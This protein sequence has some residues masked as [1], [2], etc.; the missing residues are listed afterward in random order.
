M[1]MKIL[2]NIKS[3]VFL[4]GLLCAVLIW[5][6]GPIID[7]YIFGNR[8][9]LNIGLS[10][11]AS[12]DIYEHILFSVIILLLSLVVSV[13]I[14]VAKERQKVF[15]T[16]FDNSPNSLLLVSDVGIITLVNDTACTMFGFSRE[17]LEGMQ[18]EDLIPFR[19]RGRH[20]G[21]RENYFKNITTRAMG[22]GRELYGLRSDGTEF[23]VEIGLTGVEFERGA[24]NG[25]MKL[26]LGTITDI[27]ARKRA[28]EKLNYFATH[29][30]L[31]GLVNRHEFERRVNE[32]LTDI[33]MNR[34]EHALCYIDLDQFRVI[35][36]TCGHHAGDEMLQ[37][38][39]MVLRNIVRDRDT[40]ARL[41]G[42]EFAVLMQHCS[43]DNAVRVAENLLKSINDFQYNYENKMFR[44]GASIGLVAITEELANFR[45]LM[46]QAD[47]ACFTAKEAGRNRVHV[48]KAYEEHAS[49]QHGDMKWVAVLHQA[50][51]EDRLRLYAQAIVPLDGSDDTHYELL[52]RMLDDD[53]GVIPPGQFLPAAERYNI[54]SKIDRW[55]IATAFEKVIAVETGSDSIKLSINLSAQSLNEPGFLEYVI[56][57]I[58]STGINANNICFEITETAAIANLQPARIFMT[59]LK[60]IGC[61]FALDDFGTGHS[62]FG[63]LKKL[64]VDYLKIDGV[65][66]KEIVNDRIDLAMVKSIN[67]IGHTMGMKT[68]AEFVENNEIKELLQKIGVNYAQGYGIGKPVPLEEK[69]E[70][71][72]LEDVTI[73]REAASA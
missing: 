73:M 69:L 70:A 35:N 4:V 62:S 36:D 47:L 59:T 20:A 46:K 17:K 9:D 42:D 32:M 14:D 6:A 55:V 31:T 25:G 72:E 2:K 22:A 23:P 64:P 65:F 43:V 61:K 56:E 28:E 33:D 50:L 13:L 19:Y 51:A 49:G 18:V 40:L 21:S 24:V 54:I 52:I 8:T 45:E 71:E 26:A 7:V 37:Q 48:Y 58:K 10:S 30:S 12:H 53:G 44:V 57:K 67:E 38:L 60:E 16:I 1:R 66:V 3:P 27:T 39:T 34:D 63:Y 5:V 29:D 15:Q 68:I 11:F 41:G